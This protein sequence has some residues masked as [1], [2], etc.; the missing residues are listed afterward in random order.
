MT[1]EIL[2]WIAIVLFIGGYIYDVY[3]IISHHGD[4]YD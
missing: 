4:R 3:Y 2:K 1:T